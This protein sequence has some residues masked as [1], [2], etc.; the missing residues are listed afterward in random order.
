MNYFWRRYAASGFVFLCLFGGIYLLNNPEI[1]KKGI[2]LFTRK[3]ITKSE[4]MQVT[5]DA[6]VP[7]PK[8]LIPTFENADEW[9][10]KPNYAVLYDEEVVQARVTVHKISKNDVKGDANRYGI[11][12][13]EDEPIKSETAAW[14]DYTG[15]G[16]D[17]GHLVPAGDFQCCQDLLTATFA[18]SNVAPFDSAFN[19]H[20]W[21]DL[22][23]YIR[24]MVR[25]KGEIYVF[26]GPVFKKPLAFIGR[27]HDIQIPSHFFKVMVYMPDQQTKPI[28]VAAYLLPNIPLY[29]FHE[30]SF[31]ISIDNLEHQTGVDFFS[32]LPDE[33]EATFENKVKFGTW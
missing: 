1:V 11:R 22:E 20:A 5:F 27:F 18:M 7:Y 12:F 13:Q 31:R 10:I 15:T 6:N 29:E 21:Q 30:E 25:K 19:R 23:I 9:I 16:F 32:Y 33:I 17:R 14:K 3:E 24:K 26:T 8:T 28:A 2:K 4:I